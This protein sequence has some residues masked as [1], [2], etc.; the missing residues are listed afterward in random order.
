MGTI[1]YK[2]LAV[3]G[4]CFL[5]R[6]LLSGTRK[7]LYTHFDKITVGVVIALTALTHFLV[8]NKLMFLEIYFLPTLVAGY[9]LGR[10]S[11]ISVAIFSVAL[12]TYFVV[13]SPVRYLGGSNHA[14]LVLD[15]ILWGCFLVLTSVVVGTL[16]EQNKEKNSELKKAYDGVLEIL[17]KFI[18]SADKYTNGHSRRVAELA[19]EMAINMDLPDRQIETVRVAALLHDIGKVDISTDVILKAAK[20]SDDEIKKLKTHV[21]K[22]K[23]FLNPFRQ[24]FKDAV[25][26]ILAHH[27]YYDNSGYGEKAPLTEQNS[28]SLGILTLADAYDAMISDRPYRQGKTPRQALAEI[29]RL[30]GKQF[31]PMLVRAFT[32]VMKDRVEAA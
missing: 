10:R 11:G 3:P 30:S 29:I 1:K 28:I 14:Q 22:S 4:D 32:R 9:V 13:I 18:D 21:E 8:V 2:P 6:P 12:V 16:Y 7:F 31:D 26:I 5:E 23:V 15:L 19:T 24:L 20:L 17:S 27:K 25:A